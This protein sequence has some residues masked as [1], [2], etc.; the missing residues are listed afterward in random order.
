VPVFVDVREDTLNVNETLVEAAITDRTRVI[1]VVHY[2]GVGCEM[3]SLRELADRNGLL[4]VEDAAQGFGSDF[5]GESLGTIGA[6]GVLSFH[7]TKNVTSGEGGALVVND[8][9]LVERAEILHEKG[10]NRAAFFRGQVDKYTWVDLGS[11][12]VASEI[13]AAFLWAQLQQSDWIAAQRMVI[14]SRYNDAFAELESGGALRRP[15]VPPGLHHN[16]HMYYVL[17]PT[18]R[19]RDAAIGALAR[20]GVIAVFH[21]VPLHTSPAGR[22]FGR[23][24][25][26]LPVAEDVSGRLVRL[27]LW[28][29]MSNEQVDHVIDAVYRVVTR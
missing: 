29:G 19:E 13:A 12:F 15:V 28:V 6:L 3:T 5:Q 25:G 17:L 10:T 24:A 7:E 22:R 16:A 4:L 27:P 14:W 9:S 21:Y 2:A 23:P 20:L 18:V 1:G 26:R 8:A 11:S